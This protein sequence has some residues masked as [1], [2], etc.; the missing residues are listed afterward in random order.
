MNSGGTE[1]KN[2]ASNLSIN[3]P[4]IWSSATLYDG[5]VVKKREQWFA[6]FLNNHPTPNTAGRFG[7]SSIYR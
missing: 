7:F 6:S 4:Y 1:Q 5:F 2:I 3:R